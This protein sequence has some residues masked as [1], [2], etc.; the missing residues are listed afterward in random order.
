MAETSLTL[1][2]GRVAPGGLEKAAILLLTLGPDVAASV[3]RHLN[4]QEVRQLSTAIARLRSIS[5]EQAAAVHEE[6]WR[7]LGVD[8]PLDK[9]DTTISEA[10]LGDLMGLA[11]RILKGE[12]RGRVVVDVNR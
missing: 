9:L 2:S 7:R 10:G 6:A 5:K 8:L 11:P 12:I 4:E 1:R 3:F